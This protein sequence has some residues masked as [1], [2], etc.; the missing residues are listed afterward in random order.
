[1]AETAAHT[2]ALAGE[3][4]FPPF[5][6]E[7]FASQLV[8]LALTFV[9]LYVL[10]SRIALPRIGSIMAERS[11]RIAEHIAAARG[12]NAQA[13]ATQAARDK[14]LA[15]ARDRARA[16]IGLEYE[17]LTAAGRETIARLDALLGERLAA[18]ER[19]ITAAQ[20]SALGNVRNVAAE[21]APAIVQRLTGKSPSGPEIAAAIAEHSL[22][23]G[24]VDAPR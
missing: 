1:M 24:S 21:L 8:W 6:A 9:L 23:E 16:V 17:R 7:N 15:D 22:L 10:M 12:F 4:S 14:S 3:P 18:A 20:A 2:G 19:S 5:Q 13:G 11:K